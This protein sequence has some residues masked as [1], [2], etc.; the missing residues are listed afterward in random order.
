[1]AHY[2]WVEEDDHVD[3]GE[4]L[5]R[6][7]HLGTYLAQPRHW[8]QLA[9]GM[10]MSNFSL[11]LL[12]CYEELRYKRLQDHPD[13]S[14]FEQFNI[15]YPHLPTLKTA[16]ENALWARISADQGY[17]ECVAFFRTVRPDLLNLGITERNG[18]VARFVLILS[19]WFEWVRV[20]QIETLPQPRSA[21]NIARVNTVYSLFTQVPLY[22]V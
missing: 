7:P 21:W 1:M 20:N 18:W 9:V 11:G 19:T 13:L 15:L 2:Q 4:E 17:Q 6:S 12:V 5:V 22:T 10:S 3:D 8:E 16:V 14:K